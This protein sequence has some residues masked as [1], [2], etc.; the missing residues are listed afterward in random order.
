MNRRK[1]PM[2][3]N[4]RGELPRNAMVVPPEFERRTQEGIAVTMNRLDEL[5]KKQQ[6][7]LDAELAQA[8][9]GLPMIHWVKRDTDTS[10]WTS[11]AKAALERSCQPRASE[12]DWPTERDYR[13][14]RWLVGSLVLLAGGIILALA[15][16]LSF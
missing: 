11:E 16:R 3:Q 6:A 7:K 1:I 2:T 8:F 4:E 15:L 13:G 9:T 12:D 10:L 5:D 14:V